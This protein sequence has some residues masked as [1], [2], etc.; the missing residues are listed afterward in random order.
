MDVEDF[1]GTRFVVAG[2]GATGVAATAALVDLGAQVT[3]VDSRPQVAAAADLPAGVRVHADPDWSSLADLAL[4]QS[5]AI[6][7]T[8][9]GLPPRTPLLA[10]AV[11]AGIPV[12]SEVELAWQICDPSVSWLTLTGTNGKTTTV[13]MLAAILAAAGHRAPAVGNVGRSIVTTVLGARAAGSALDAVAVELSSFQLHFTHS[14]SPVA[15]CCLNIADDHQDWYD[16]MATYAADKARVYT[17]T[18]LACVYNEM[19]PQTRAMVEEADVTEGA[20]A[21]G[22]TLGAPRV[23]QLG[24]VEDLLADRA[25]DGARHHRAV[26]LATVADLAHLAPGQVPGHLVSNALAAAGLARAYGVRADDVAHGLR[27]YTGDGHRIE[28]V[29]T[30]SGVHYVND[31]KAT[32]A[33]AASASLA[34]LEPGT[35]VWIAGGLAKGA[36]FDDLVRQIAD[37]LRAVVVIGT[38]PAP[39]V[40]ALARH[41]PDLPRVVVP[42]GETEVMTT[43][44]AHAATL[45]RSGDVVLLAPAS[46]SQD[47]FSSYAARGEAFIE[48]VHARETGAT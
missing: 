33:H 35:G 37:R 43:A 46:A 11:A 31:S 27:A 15:S 32:N 18:R 19:E 45:A 13:G 38:D 48:A 34:A 24:V 6:V 26:E 36:R 5:P 12:W 14:L 25:F 4:D 8:S 39:I 47:Q 17:G 2:L 7:V 30:I 3:A 29:A 9:P 44:V 23:G 21:V 28:Q 16:S 10:R 41:A 42:P 40:S 22:F 20:R 1:S